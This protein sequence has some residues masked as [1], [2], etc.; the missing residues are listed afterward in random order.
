MIG[1]QLAIATNLIFSALLIFLIR[2][3]IR[4]IGKNERSVTAVFYTFGLISL[5]LSYLYWLAYSLIRP[6]TRMPFAPNEVG[7][8][9]CIL[10]IASTVQTVFNG[11]TLDSVR[12]TV[13]AIFLQAACVGLWIGWSGEWIQDIIAAFVMFYFV[14][15]TI[16]SLKVSD[17]L[18]KTEWKMLGGSMLLLV[19]LQGLTFAVPKE[20]LKPLDT[21]CYVLIFAICAYY[22]YIF[23]KAKKEGY[24][25]EKIMS[26]SC[27]GYLYG[28]NAMYMSAEPMYFIAELFMIIM[29]VILTLSVGR[30]VMKK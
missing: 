20:I 25:N 14:Y 17:A 29:L 2:Y 7:E 30:A 27:C 22:A 6:D 8:N 24:D 16:K 23:I 13:F 11:K 19:L 5:L 12:E 3:C 28:L 26:L 21:V 15:V 10:L 18:S 4:L 1:N 9:A